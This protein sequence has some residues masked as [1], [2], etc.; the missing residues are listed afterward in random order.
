MRV[1]KGL[2]AALAALLAAVLCCFVTTP[3]YAVGADLTATG[4]IT[5]TMQDDGDVVS[6]GSV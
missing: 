5:L 3:A 2:G 4:S 1:R 6:G